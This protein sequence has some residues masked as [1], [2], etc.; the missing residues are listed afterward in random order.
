[1][2]GSNI[3]ITCCDFDCASANGCRI[4]GV[5]CVDCGKYFC[6]TEIDFA[7]G[8]WLCDECAK[9]R[10]YENNENESEAEG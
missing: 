9:E 1:M 8:E 6:A 5:C 7:D 10:E 2:S 3:P 4:G